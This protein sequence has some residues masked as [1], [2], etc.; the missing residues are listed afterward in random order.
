MTRIAFLH[1]G[2]VVIPAFASL[3]AELLPDVEVQNLLDDKIVGDLGHGVAPEQIEQR[4]ADLGHAAVAAGAD[5]VLFPCSSISQNADWRLTSRRAQHD[6]TAH[7]E[8]RL[9]D[10][11]GSTGAVL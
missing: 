11:G 9:T 7:P 4:L 2:A 10:A 8:K 3:A 1:T 6:A 5:A